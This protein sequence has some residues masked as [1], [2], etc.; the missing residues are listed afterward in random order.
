MT[1]KEEGLREF[2]ESPSLPVGLV[3]EIASNET[4][5]LDNELRY[6]A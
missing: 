5:P 4:Y 2:S 1:I 3:D 6:Q